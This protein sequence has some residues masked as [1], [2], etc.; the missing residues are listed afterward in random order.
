MVSDTIR[1]AVWQELLDAAR[2]ARYYASLADRHR[3]K[4]RIIQLLLMAAATSGIVGVLDLVPAFMQQAAF[5]AVAILILWD[6]IGDY[7]GKA[8][9]LDT[10]RIECT[11]LENQLLTLWLEVD[12][13]DMEDADA[14][15]QCNTLRQGLSDATEPAGKVGVTVDA[16]LNKTCAEDAYKVMQERFAT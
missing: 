12:Q 10:I 6:L 4:R 5:A 2:L 11:L 16:R 3:R 1:N 13:S 9:V 8:A 15:R 14:R 7:A